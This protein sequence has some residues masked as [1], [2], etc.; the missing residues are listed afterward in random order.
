MTYMNTTTQCILH[1][2]V[3]VTHASWWPDKRGG[4]GKYTWRGSVAVTVGDGVE[5]AVVSWEAVRGGGWWGR[6]PKHNNLRLLS[7]ADVSRRWDSDVLGC[8]VSAPWCSDWGRLC[9]RFGLYHHV[10]CEIIQIN[11]FISYGIIYYCI[12]LK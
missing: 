1:P 11:T 3:W 12:I 2:P 5:R 4:A 7:A 8:A 10:F 9:V 6:R